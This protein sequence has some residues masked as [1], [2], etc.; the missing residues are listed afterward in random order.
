MPTALKKPILIKKKVILEY[1]VPNPENDRFIA[2]GQFLDSETLAE[3]TKEYQIKTP[4]AIRI[5]NFYNKGEWFY[6]E[7][8]IDI[9]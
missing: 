7:V 6:F 1:K 5:G 8:I 4:K 3:L 2:P 9:G